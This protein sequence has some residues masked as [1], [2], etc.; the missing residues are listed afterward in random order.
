MGYSPFYLVF[1]R[2]P[3]LPIDLLIPLPPADKAT[4]MHNLE[5]PYYIQC[6]KQHMQQVYGDVQMSAE[7]ARN[8][9]KGTYDQKVNDCF[10]QPGDTVLAA[11][12]SQRG[13]AK[14]WDRWET[15][16]YM[17]VR[18]QWGMPV[19]VVQQIGSQDT[20][21]LHRIMLM[22]C[23]FDMDSPSG[24]SSSADSQEESK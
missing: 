24:K 8:K 1:L 13:K 4:L 9:Q 22:L 21:T 2:K 20:R 5:Y 16:P 14:L 11:N 3:K 7:R 15:T 12:K 19:Y 17:V 23:L 10:L 6:L 18:N